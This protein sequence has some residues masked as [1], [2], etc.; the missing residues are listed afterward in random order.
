[1]DMQLYMRENAWKFLGEDGKISR[2][3][4]RAVWQWAGE[5]A[6]AGTALATVDGFR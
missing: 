4:W 6:A 2:E 3:V 5:G 1:M